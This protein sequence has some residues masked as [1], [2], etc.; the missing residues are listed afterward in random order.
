M[1]PLLCDFRQLLP[2]DISVDRRRN[3]DFGGI[4]SGFSS[5]R[6]DIFKYQVAWIAASVS[7]LFVPSED[8][9]LKNGVTDVVLRFKEDCDFLNLL[10]AVVLLANRCK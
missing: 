3:S 10:R 9:N 1:L 7:G 2:H 4:P 5:R 6:S 8:K